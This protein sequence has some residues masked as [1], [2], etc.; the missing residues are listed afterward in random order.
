[1]APLRPRRLPTLAVMELVIDFWCY[2][3]FSPF[4]DWSCLSCMQNLVWESRGRKARFCIHD[5]YAYMHIRKQRWSMTNSSTLHCLQSISSSAQRR[6]LQVCI[7]PAA[8]M[9][10]FLKYDIRG[11]ELVESFLHFLSLRSICRKILNLKPQQLA[12]AAITDSHQQD[13]LVETIPSP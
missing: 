6:N 7:T 8:R 9:Y 11:W 1:M 13:C 3:F 4:A 5:T 12:L 2:W 10:I